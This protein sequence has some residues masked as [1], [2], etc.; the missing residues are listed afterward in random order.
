MSSKGYYKRPSLV[1]RGRGHVGVFFGWGH[2]YSY[3]VEYH[4]A[5]TYIHFPM[6]HYYLFWGRR[7]LQDNAIES[8]IFEAVAAARLQVGWG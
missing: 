3:V 4:F 2:V 8:R 6:Y 1:V 7:L 5:F